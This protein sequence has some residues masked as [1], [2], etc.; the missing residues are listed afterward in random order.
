ME[1]ERTLA[2]DRV[3]PVH[4]RRAL[5]FSLLVGAERVGEPVTRRVERDF[6]QAKGCFVK[7]EYLVPFQE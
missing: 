7:V 3:D 1:S 2:D 4:Y 6:G 5:R